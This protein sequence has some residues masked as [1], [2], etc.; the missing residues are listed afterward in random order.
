MLIQDITRQNT[1]LLKRVGSAHPYFINTVKG[2]IFVALVTKAIKGT[3]DVLPKEV[4]KN[5]YIEATALDI[6]EKFGYKEIRTPVFEYTELFQRGVGDTTDVV[7]KEMYTFNDKGD[8][9]IT[10]R[11]EGTAG[12]VRSYLENGLNNET[13]PQKVC[14]IGPCFRYEKPQAG[15]LR[16]FHQFGVECFGTQSPLADAEMIALAK[17]LFD[18]LGIKDLSLEINSIGCPEC[19]ANYHK[20]LKEYFASRKDELCQTCQDRLDR[21]PM[22]ILDCKSPICSE[23]AKG[24]PVV[25]DYLCDECRDHFNK[26]KAY[27]DAQ[28][29]QYNVNPKIVR[30]LDYY[31]KTVFEF[32]S[33][34]IG[35]QGT[36]A[37]GGRYD[38]LVSELGGQPTPS[39][40]FAVGLERLMMIMEAQ[41]CEFPAPEQPDLFIAALGEK[42]TLKA[43][44]IAK[45][46][47]AE[48]FSTIMDLNQR[49]IR[50]Q[51]KYADK[52]CA[53]FNVV[54]GDNEVD[55]GI[56]KLKNMQ[57]GEETEIALE[58]FVNGFYDISLSQQLADLEINGEALDF[59]SLFSVGNEE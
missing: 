28:N 27:L 45:D 10:L 57:S 12:A 35:A 41:G 33:N 5:Q 20:A 7:Q 15:R 31:T 1:K 37:G 36:V 53:K 9:S 44:E 59:T 23:I 30:G 47:R 46:M 34:S 8:R 54:I 14:Y 18:T 13:L 16:E 32:V 40:G 49:S 42:A 29:I 17:A 19:R 26:V 58:T 43:V 55:T 25:I 50:A 52:L 3:K 51:M 2:G 56:A 39:L 48:G 11:P 38:G 22:R 21:N 24:A 6:A 4:H